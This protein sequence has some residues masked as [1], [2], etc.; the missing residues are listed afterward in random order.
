MIAILRTACAAAV[1]CLAATSAS[2]EV[3]VRVAHTLST[4]DTH[5]LAAL[6]L[7]ELVETA[8]N[9]EVRVSVHPA[10]ELGNDP[11]LL[12]GIRLGTIDVAFTGN[13]FYTRFEPKL[14]VIDLP[15]L[16]KNNE[17]VYRVID[18]PIGQELLAGLEKHRMKPLAF[19]E[20]GF[21]HITNS[22]RAIKTP[23][24][25]EGL[26]IRT[27]PNPAHVLAFKLLG[28]I[29][30]PMPFT[31]VYMAL[32]THA[33]DGQENPVFQITANRLHEVQKHMSL[34]GHAY[35][36]SIIAMSQTKWNGL[37]A[38]QQKVMMDAAKEAQIYQRELNRKATVES[39][40]LMRKAGLGIVEDIDTSAF[41]SVVTEQVKANYVKDHGSTIVDA[42]LKASQ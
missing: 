9:G 3:R 34:T 13:P 1:V 32:E 35:T 25:L 22:K 39:M 18:G 16:F 6:K 14:N 11:A 29:P 7:K 28:A 8:T 12:E 37:T 42:I 36:A 30:T 33:V 26:K 27:T 10:G 4:T 24:D 5:H 15:Y 2:A 31:E 20:I 23:K 40:D 17:H 19:W 41:Q 21:R 38:P